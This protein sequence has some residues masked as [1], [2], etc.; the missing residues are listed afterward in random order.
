MVFK[1]ENKIFNIYDNNYIFLTVAVGRN[2][3]KTRIIQRVRLPKLKKNVLNKSIRETETDEKNIES[4]VSDQE[5]WGS[6]NVYD[7]SSPIIRKWEKNSV[8]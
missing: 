1:N 4:E 6:G 5:E 2:I 3:I 8:L 7:G